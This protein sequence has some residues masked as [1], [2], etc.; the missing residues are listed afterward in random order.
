MKRIITLLAVLCLLIGL[1]ACGGQPEGS[2]A[3]TVPTQTAPA[4]RKE[5]GTESEAIVQSTPAESGTAQVPAG[6]KT[7]VVVFSATG[8]T[9]GVAEMIAA[10]TGADIYEIK[11]AEPYSDADLNWHDKNSRTTKEQ[12]DKTVRP[13]IGSNK[14]S[15][16]AYSRIFIGYPIWWGEEPRILDT[17]VE[18][19]DFTGIT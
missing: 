7:L 4:A 3:A 12:N 19:Y 14:I 8:T 6:D 11:A 16:D 2:T 10:I 1:A 5:P 18:K 9:K 17:F 13:A 15:F